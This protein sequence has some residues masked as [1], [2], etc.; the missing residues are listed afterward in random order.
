MTAHDLKH[1]DMETDMWT[2][3]TL[4]DYSRRVN[5]ERREA[6]RDRTLTRKQQR[7]AKRARMEA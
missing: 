7:A 3:E 1:F 6:E 4:R 2:T 5:R